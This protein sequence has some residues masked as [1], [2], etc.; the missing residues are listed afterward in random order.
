MWI[1]RWSLIAI[2]VILISFFIGKNIDPQAEQQVTIHYIFGETEPLPKLMVMFLAFVA[3]FVTWFIISLFNFFKMRS[4]LS[5]KDRLIK[6]LRQ[7]LNG[8]RNQSLNV[9]DDADKT[10]IIDLGAVRKDSPQAPG[11]DN[12]QQD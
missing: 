12:P 5:A 10:V 6:N 3:G 9:N 11:P 1:V 8:Y 2:V 4:E 7:E